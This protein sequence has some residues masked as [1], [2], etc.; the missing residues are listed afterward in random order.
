MHIVSV[1]VHVIVN[2]VLHKKLGNYIPVITSSHTM[3]LSITPGI[4]QKSRFHSAFPVIE[5][6]RIP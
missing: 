4:P 1:L 5:S 6:I 2:E 3:L